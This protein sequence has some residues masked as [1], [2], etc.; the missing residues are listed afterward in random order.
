VEGWI[1]VVWEN[2][3][4][5]F[6]FKHVN[7]FASLTEKGQMDYFYVNV[8]ARNNEVLLPSIRRTLLKDPVRIMMYGP[9]SAG[10]S[11]C[12]DAAL[13]QLNEE[14]NFVA[15]RVSLQRVNVATEELF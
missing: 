13:N 9:R 4:F 11:M 2:A 1:G 10:K 6:V 14:G 8:R 12:V 3:L 7:V 15:L 5:F